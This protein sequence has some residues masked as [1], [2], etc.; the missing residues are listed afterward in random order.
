MPPRSPS[1]E[2]PTDV[3]QW[4][5]AYGGDL[6]SIENLPGD[7]SLRR[8]SRL[9]MREGSGAILAFYPESIR[10]DCRRYAIST[11][12]LG[13]VGVDVPEI[14]AS[15]CQLGVMLLEDVGS[16]SLFDRREAGWEWVRPALQQATEMLRRIASLP[17]REVAELNP[18]LDHSLLESELSGTWDVALDAS[19]LAAAGL[20]EPL[21]V[22]FSTL[23][24]ELCAARL[25]PCHRDLM[26]RNLQLRRPAEDRVPVVVVIDH[27]DL[28]LG[29]HTYDLASLLNDSLYPPE[30]LERELAGALLATPQDW[31]DYHRAAAQRTLKIVG[32][33]VAFARRGFPRYL[34]LIEPSLR[35]ARRHLLALPEMEGLGGEIN[36][37]LNKLLPRR[38]SADLLD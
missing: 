10:D 5:A 38:P 16:E 34:G 12:L 25:V 31:L 23:L 17:T 20:P 37:L 22:G 1:T 18:P 26:A 36:D 8:Y 30:E 35:S 3:R 32:T 29:P 9:Q 2:P 14:F 15:D 7:V 19:S 13:S 4:V 6:D 24:D 28:R 33:F 27:Q 21:E 11:R